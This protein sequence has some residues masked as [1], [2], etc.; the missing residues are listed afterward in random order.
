M[1]AAFGAGVLSRVAGGEQQVEVKLH[2]CDRK[3]MMKSKKKVIVC[4]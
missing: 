1:K 3:G 4:N 2:R